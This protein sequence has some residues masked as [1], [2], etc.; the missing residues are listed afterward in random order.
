VYAE[1]TLV[2]VELPL[3]LSQGCESLVNIGNE[4][5]G[6]SGLDDHIIHID[7]DILVVLLLEADL[8]SLLIGSVCVLQ[9]ERH[10]HVAVGTERG[11][12]HGCLLVFF[13]DCDL[14]VPGVAV[15]EAEQV[16]THHGVDDLI[17]P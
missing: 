5:V 15:K 16:A 11:D 12:E 13:L 4:R 8:D 7:F 3:V 2:E 1:D 17:N 9:P 14:V 6:V 10:H